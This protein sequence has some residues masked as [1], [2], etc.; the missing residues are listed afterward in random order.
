MLSARFFSDGVFPEPHGGL[1]AV[2]NP[3]CSGQK[4]AGCRRW[5]NWQSWNNGYR[6]AQRYARTDTHTAWG[7]ERLHFAFSNGSPEGPW[8]S[9]LGGQLVYSH[10]ERKYCAYFL[11]PE[12]L[13]ATMYALS[14]PKPLENVYDTPKAVDGRLFSA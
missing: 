4:Y 8:V 6:M 2:F 1:A 11:G 7:Q 12:N 3:C 13:P 5:F 14:S 10:I 9:G